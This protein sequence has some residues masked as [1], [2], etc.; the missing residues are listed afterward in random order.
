MRHC[1]VELHHL[2]PAEDDVLVA[3]HEADA[4]GEDVEPL[5]ALIRSQLGRT[6]R[7]RDDD[8]PRLGGD[9]LTRQRDHGAPPVPWC[10]RALP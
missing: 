3:D 10:Y 4:T 8:L 2:P 6:H 1:G 9:R 5:V 7:R